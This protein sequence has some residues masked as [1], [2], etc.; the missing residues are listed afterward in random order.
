[1]K[2][3]RSLDR[4]NL[5]FIA[6][7]ALF[8]VSIASSVVPVFVSA[9][10]VTQRSIALSSSS[11]SATNVTYDVNF[12]AAGA[13]GAFII[14]FCSNTPLIGQE[15]VAPTGMSVASAASTTSG[16]TTVD[17]IAA[18][19]VMVTGAIAANDDVAVELTGI[20][21]PTVAGPVYARIVTYTAAL[22]PGVFGDYDAED[23]PAGAIDQ[24]GLAISITQ[25][26]GVSGAVPESMLFCIS[27]NVIGDNCTGTA[28]PVLELGETVGDL[29]ALVASA[30]S[31]GSVYSQISTNA[32]GGAIVHLKSDAL[33]CGGLLRAGAPTACD[34]EPA[35]DQDI[36]AG[37]AR[38]GVTATPLA[39]TATGATG[40]F[41]VVDLSG[42]S[43]SAYA[44][45]FTTGNTAG[46]TSTYGDAFL[47][48]AG[49]PANNKNV[50]LT[51]GAS[52]SN[53]TPAGLY[54]ANLSMIATGK[55]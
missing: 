29:K 41:D 3:T 24:G 49:A 2:I 45:N 16:F 11:V 32:S 4:H 5:P 43:S 26:I 53:N 1:M 7:A 19:T 35:Q 18:N 22:A 30:V 52:V 25:T 46:V 13:A 44:L 8:L 20:N 50:Q 15:C 42:Y 21:N 9:A 55:F 23:L 33:N 48:T 39:N 37:D 51:F 40:V 28:A 34:I 6:A 54:S 10:Q 17:D 27:L 47:D 31:T 12:K 14:D 38:F 36:D